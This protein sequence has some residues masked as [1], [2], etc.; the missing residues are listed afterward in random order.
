MPINSYGYIKTLARKGSTTL[1]VYKN[2]LD[3][4]DII[5][6]FCRENKFI[7]STHLYLHALDY[8]NKEVKDNA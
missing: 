8:L 6:C 1:D 5:Y 3:P 2:V 4:Q 7:Y